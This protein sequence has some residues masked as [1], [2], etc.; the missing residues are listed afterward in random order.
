[1]FEIQPVIAGISIAI[2]VGA[3]LGG[4][5]AGV[6]SYFLAP[7][8]DKQNKAGS[9][10][11]VR[12]AE[13]P[14]HVVLGRAVK[15]SVLFYI[16]GTGDD[17]KYLHLMNVYAAH[18]V[19][20]I[21]DV[22]FD[23]QRV[24]INPHELPVPHVLDVPDDSVYRTNS[25]NGI[26]NSIKI[27]S[28][29]STEYEDNAELYRHD[30]EVG[31]LA[32]AQ[33]V[34]LNENWTDAHTV[35]GQAY[36]YSILE[37]DSEV[38][39]S[40][41]PRITAEIYGVKDVY[42][43]RDGVSRWT[44]NPALLASYVLENLIKVGREDI[45]QASLIE[46][47]NICDEL[48]ITKNG[49]ALPRY[50]CNGVLELD[51]DWEK[52]LTPIITSMAGAVVEWGGT[53]YI[54][55]GA[56]REPVLT[57]SDSDFMGAFNR[58]ISGADRDRANSVK[59]T[60]V[61]PQSYEE[62]TEFPVLKNAVYIGEDGGK[63]NWLELELLYVNNH[64]QAQ[65]LSSIYL[66]EARQDETISVEVPLHIGLD[67]M[68]FDNITLESAIFG[69]SENYRVID[70][71]VSQ[72]AALTVE[73][74]LKRHSE[75]VYDWDADFDERDI[76]NA[77]TT[78]AGVNDAS[79][80]TGSTYTLTPFSDDPDLKIANV[81]CSWSDPTTDF[82]EIEIEVIMSVQYRLQ[83][84]GTGQAGPWVD[85]TVTE[86]R[87][88]LPSVQSSVFDVADESFSAEGYDFQNHMVDVARIRTKITST[89]YSSWL[90]IS[91]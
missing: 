79:N 80:P 61:S 11:N 28:D 42:D 85:L 68:V 8:T 36:L 47:A 27:S 55:A 41:I 12:S 7:K 3:L 35:S 37:Y 31:Q 53:Y 2:G 21:G 52:W 33:A 88:V 54:R 13:S 23:A 48:Y 90:L 38:Y 56:W 59:G 87:S 50:T 57:I 77:K 84:D 45:D 24:S 76:Q 74:I 66:N 9:N 18:E 19:E 10:A 25:A 29:T 49:L 32:N 16:N 75:S 44:Q 46:A 69:F 63:E 4:L 86:N 64:Q 14:Q 65:R 91:A 6:A 70:H 73:L 83:D 17:N 58:Q 22:F 15:G 40:F 62:V 51:G 5:A 67:V 43:P 82:E 1:M 60:Y 81:S 20:S 78:L 89:E 34:L 30:G 26:Y 39:P 72:S 71:R